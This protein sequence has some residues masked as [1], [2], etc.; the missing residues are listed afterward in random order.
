MVEGSI[1]YCHTL[2]II[3]GACSFSRVQGVYVSWEGAMEA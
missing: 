1:L 3:V 2:L